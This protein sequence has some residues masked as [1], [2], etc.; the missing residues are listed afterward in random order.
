[1]QKLTG[2][3]QSAVTWT[4][5]RDALSLIADAFQMQTRGDFDFVGHSPAENMLRNALE[6][7]RVRSRGVRFEENWKKDAPQRPPSFED[8][9]TVWAKGARI[10]WQMSSAD[11]VSAQVWSDRAIP[12]Y[13][14]DYTYHRI[15]VA[16]EDVS[17][18]LPEGYEP[19]ITPALPAMSTTAEPHSGGRLENTAMNRS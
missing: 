8:L 5:L 13:R 7:G 15:E 10:N 18:L 16:R 3:S 14:I 12:D 6:D 11:V 17:K 9:R 4:L 19:P 1:M 2:G